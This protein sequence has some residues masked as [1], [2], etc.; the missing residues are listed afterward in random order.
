MMVW[1]VANQKGGVGKTTTAISL[2]G[3]MSERGYKVLLV[4]M[5]PHC[6]LSYYLDID[7]ESLDCSGYDMFVAAREASAIDI[8]QCIAPTGV[9]GIDIMPANMAMATLDRK[10]G[11]TEG[12]GLILKHALSLV[13]K[14]YDIAIIDCPP[15]LGVLMVNALAASDKILVPVQTE[16]LALKG[17]E[18]MIMSLDIMKMSPNQSIDYLV[19]PTMFDKRTKAG[20]QAMETLNE[21]YGDR[22]WRSVIP[23]DTRFRDASLEHVPPSIFAAQARGVVAYRELLDDLIDLHVA[24]HT[25]VAS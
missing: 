11:H 15:V 21:Q 10:F 25:E 13:A 17:L 1:T 9:D 14:S 3:L 12:M 16:Y 7:T 6:S 2:A 4:D 19:V 5:D 8:E 20:G 18:R 22:V 23:V 24:K